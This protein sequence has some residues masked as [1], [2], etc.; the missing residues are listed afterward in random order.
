MFKR[1]TNRKCKRENVIFFTFHHKIWLQSSVVY[2]IAFCFI[3]RK[4]NIFYH[5][6]GGSKKV[7]KG[8]IS[9]CCESYQIFFILHQF[10]ACTR[11][12]SDKTPHFLAEVKE[13]CNRNTCI[14]LIYQAI[15]WC[16]VFVAFYHTV[17]YMCRRTKNTIF[18]ANENSLNLMC[19]I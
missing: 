6:G 1:V 13:V 17:I 11:N 18:Q 16:G 8:H 10:C 4:Q 2:K 12:N 5:Q 15:A 19:A 9:S 3:I 14:V 7:Q